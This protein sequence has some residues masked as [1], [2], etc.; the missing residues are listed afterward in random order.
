MSITTTTDPVAPA[1][2]VLPAAAVPIWAGSP[3][4]DRVRE[5]ARNR[6]PFVDVAVSGG[7]RAFVVAGLAEE[8]NRASAPAERPS[9]PVLLVTATTRE[10]E[11]LAEALR[12]FLPA[13]RVASSRP[14]RPCRTS[15][16]ARAATPSAAGWPC[17]AGWPTPSPTTGTGRCPS[18]SRRCGR[19]LQPVAKGSATWSRSRS[20]PATRCR[21]RTS[22][23]AGRGGVHPDRPGRAA[24]RVRRARRD[25]RR[26]PADR[27]A[28]AAGRVLRRHGRGGP[29]VRGRRP[30]QPRDRPAR[31]VGAAVPR[32]AAHRRRP[33]A[34]AGAG[35]ASCPAW[36]TCSPR[37]PRAS[38][39]RAWSRSA[40]ALVDGDGAAARRAARAAP[41]SCSATPSGSAPGPTTWSRRARSSWRPAGSTPRP[42]TPCRSTSRACWAPR[43]TGRW[44]RSASTPARS[45]CRGGRSA[46]SPATPSW[47]SQRA[48]RCGRRRAGRPRHHRVETYRGDTERAVAQLG[49]W[50]ADEW[51]VVVVTEGHGLAKRVVELLGEHDVAATPR[52]RRR[53]GH[54]DGPRPRADRLAG[55]RVPRARLRLAVLTEADL[56]GP[57]GTASTRDMR[58]MPSRRRNEVDPLPLRPGDYVVHEQHGV[59]RFVEMAQRTV[60][61]ATRE[62]LLIEY[63]LEQA[64]PAGG[65]ALRA[66]RPARPGDPLRRRRGADAEQAGRLGLGQDQG[67]RPQGGQ[68]DRGRADPALLG[69]DGLSWLRVQPGHALAARARGRLRLRRDAGPAGHHRRGQGRHGAADPDGPAGLRRRRLRQDR[70]RRARGV[71]GGAGRQAGRDPG[72]DDPAG[73]AAHP[74]LHRPVRA[75][76]GRRQ[77]A[78]RF[79][80]DAEARAVLEG[81]AD[82]RST[83]SSAPTG[84]SARCGSR[85]SGSSWSTR[86][87]GSAS[88]TRSAEDAAHGGRRAGH[89]RHPDPADAGDGGDR[90][91]R[92]VHS[93]NAS[94]G[95]APGPDLRRRLR[96]AADHRGDPARAAARGPG[97]LRP[98]QGQLD[99]AGRGRLRELVPEARIADGAR[100]DGRAQARAGRRST[101]GRRSSTSWSA[102]RSSRPG[103][104]SPTPTP[105]SSTGPT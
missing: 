39:S 48:G 28:P 18:S 59:G 76:P 54:R 67:P 8:E 91:P 99:R 32:G 89:E 66:D 15:G 27:G 21:S 72:A 4:M 1:G 41:R 34:R 60:Q 43:R 12:C 37:W 2:V 20:R 19:V 56:T 61:G 33:R 69:P 105:W 78:V 50:V 87:S 11:D 46:R 90:H 29:L 7:A 92:D 71:Q 24:R 100:P 35:R 96:G 47:P 5:A 84:C 63:A 75:V 17:C 65:P 102:R 9:R 88:S 38:P 42:A 6:L 40:R 55:P 23:T 58:K 80:S 94:R 3:A 103:W 30:A 26:L 52:G 31:P 64:R 86:S 101:S 36:P 97:L 104:T 22:S 74:D 93:R 95:A 98:Q 25:P 14:G 85:T 57:T 73:A 82:G 53:R 45:A 70:D 79:V 51:R 10:A 81:L 68:A 44:P 13:E 49:G 77:A 16:S 83:S 62:Y